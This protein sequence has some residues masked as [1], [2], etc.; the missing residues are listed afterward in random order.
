[1][2]YDNWKLDNNEK[3]NCCDKCGQKT[4]EYTGS[5][6]IGKLELV[7]ENCAENLQFCESCGKV[8]EDEDFS[9]GQE[10]CNNC[11]VLKADKLM[12]ND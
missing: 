8:G 9:Y 4:D 1:M 12:D 3:E 6:G 2:D 5:F 11:C 7:C 10:N